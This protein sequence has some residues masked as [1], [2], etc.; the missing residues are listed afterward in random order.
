MVFGTYPNLLLVERL[1]FGDIKSLQGK[2]VLDDTYRHFVE[3][4]KCPMYQVL[5]NFYHQPKWRPRE[6]TLQMGA[7]WGWMTFHIR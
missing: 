7:G 1:F 4:L 5:C 6:L 3:L 2:T